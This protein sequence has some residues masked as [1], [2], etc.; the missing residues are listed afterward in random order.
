MYDPEARLRTLALIERGHSLRAVS[1]STGISRSTLRD[2]RDIPE[3]ARRSR[4]S[5][6]RCADDARLPE[7]CADYA[8]LL[9]LYLGDGSIS[10]AGDGTKGVWRL[11]I[12]CADDW[13]GLIQ[14][15]VRVMRAIRPG[16]KVSAQQRQGCTEVNSYSKHWPCLFPQHGPGKKHLR[17]IELAPWQRVI[18]ERYPGDFARGLFH[19]D[20]YRGINRVRPRREISE[21]SYEYPRYLFVNRSQDILELCGQALDRLGVAWRFSKPG[22]ISVARKEAVARLDEFVGP[23]Y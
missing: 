6:P 7:P 17:A 8:Y 13:P 22:T 23:K 3:K 21:R 19:S 11:S 2:W 9:G 10:V 12:F 16:N 20:G 4:R 14:E 5:C 18:V 15:C 1:R